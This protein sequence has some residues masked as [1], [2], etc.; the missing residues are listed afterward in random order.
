MYSNLFVLKNGPFAK[1]DAIS[2][3][4]PAY[5]RN[6]KKVFPFMIA[7]QTKLSPNADPIRP[8]P[9][10]DIKHAAGFLTQFE[11]DQEYLRYRLLF[12]PSMKSEESHGKIISWN[13]QKKTEY[14]INNQDLDLIR[15]NFNQFRSEVE[16]KYPVSCPSLLPSFFSF[17]FLFL[18]FL[19]FLFFPFF[20]SFPSFLSFLSFLFPFFPLFFPCFFLSFLLFSSLFFSDFTRKLIFRLRKWLK[21]GGRKNEK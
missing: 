3:V 5:F 10:G 17:F 19:F 16:A 14:P 9:Q 13:S 11:I 18:F 20:P 6:P 1:V 4:I 7:Y 12:D 15:A 21:D 8:A 2:S